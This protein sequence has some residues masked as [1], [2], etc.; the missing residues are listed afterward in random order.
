MSLYDM[1][2]TNA[3]TFALS[4]ALH[5]NVL[6]INLD[7]WG[8]LVC[9]V[10]LFQAPW[11]PTR[12][13]TCT[14]RLDRS[15]FPCHV[16]LWTDPSKPNDSNRSLFPVDMRIPAGSDTRRF[17]PRFPEIRAQWISEYPH[18]LGSFAT[19]ARANEPAPGGA[20]PELT[21]APHPA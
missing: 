15:R 4:D 21:F 14:L 1:G 3:L 11:L 20:R 9:S 10:G 5:E 6:E 12:E 17:D 16:V 18:L 2:G 13:Y 7:E 8:F 19:P